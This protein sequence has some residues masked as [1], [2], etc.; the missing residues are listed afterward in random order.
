[1]KKATYAWLASLLLMLVATLT[2]CEQF[3]L[4]ESGTSTHDANVNVTLHLSVANKKQSNA[5]KN[6][7]LDNGLSQISYFQHSVL[8][9]PTLRALNTGFLPAFFCAS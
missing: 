7:L 6:K 3:A 8:L 1:M 2:S 9:I 5:L 4:D